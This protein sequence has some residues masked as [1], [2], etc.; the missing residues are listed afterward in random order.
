MKFSKK[1]VCCIQ[2]CFIPLSWPGILELKKGPQ[3]PDS[4][5]EDSLP[6][7][8]AKFILFEMKFSKKNAPRKK[9][10]FQKWVFSTSLLLATTVD[11]LVQNVQGHGWHS[12]KCSSNECEHPGQTAKWIWHVEQL[13]GLFWLAPQKEAVDA[14]KVG[15]LG[16][17]PHHGAY[18]KVTSY[19]NKTRTDLKKIQWPYEKNSF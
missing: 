16:K 19:V 14:G 11:S 5:Q 4:S 10:N 15:F 7:R 8:F 3:H 12:G 17:I 1:K 6:Y 2:W 13:G 18:H 9:G